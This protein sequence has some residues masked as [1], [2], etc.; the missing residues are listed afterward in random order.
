MVFV[1]HQDTLSPAIIAVLAK[2]NDSLIDASFNRL[3]GGIDPMVDEV[4]IVVV[5]S[6]SSWHREAMNC[7]ID[8]GVVLIRDL[9]LDT[10]DTPYTELGLCHRE[11]T[12]AFRKEIHIL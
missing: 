1:W 6:K 5:I 7:F 2:A 4:L 9:A 8:L 3:P 10:R 12:E 11:H